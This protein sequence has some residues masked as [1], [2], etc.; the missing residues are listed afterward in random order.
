MPTETGKVA[1][2][3]TE[4]LPVQREGRNDG[5]IAMLT[6]VTARI[7]AEREHEHESVRSAELEQRNA[8]AAQASDDVLQQLYAI[9]L[10]LDRLSRHPEQLQGKAEPVLISL[11][12]TVDRLRASITQVLLGRRGVLD[13]RRHPPARRGLGGPDGEPPGRRGRGGRGRAEPGDDPSPAHRDLPD[14]GD[15]RAARGRSVPDQRRGGRRSRRRHRGRRGLA[16]GRT[17]GVRPDVHPGPRRRREPGDR[18]DPPGAHPG[19]LEIRL[20][21]AR[22]SGHRVRGA[23]SRPST[24]SADVAGPEREAVRR[25]RLHVDQHLGVRPRG[26]LPAVEVDLTVRHRP[27]QDVLAADAE[28]SLGE[29]HRRAAPAAAGREHQH[30]GPV[31]VDDASQRFLGGCRGPQSREPEFPHC[32]SRSS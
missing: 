3:L 23:R 9:G 25:A 6:D 29:A 32:R 12:E 10:H 28:L 1:Y 21:N 24:R 5:F 19:H 2:A 22:S 14:P 18:H 16:A 31:V 30:H 26:Q 11:Q 7:L 17:V 13:R 20:A 15:G 8:E 27:D 4:Y